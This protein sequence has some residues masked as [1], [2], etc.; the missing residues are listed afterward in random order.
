MDLEQIVD[1]SLIPKLSL[2]HDAVY[3]A[4]SCRYYI[5]N[6]DI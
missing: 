6:S 2:F 3:Q 1:I 5:S 4:L